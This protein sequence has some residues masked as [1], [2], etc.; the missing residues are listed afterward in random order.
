MSARIDDPIGAFVDH[1]PG[2]IEGSG[3][4]PLAGLTF[5]VKDLYHIEGHVTGGGSPDWLRA[6]E[7]ATGTATAVTKLLDAGADM[8]GKTVCD[9]LFYSFSGANAH[10]GT[11]TNVRAPG[12]VPGGSSSGSAAAVAAGLCDFA[13][14]TDTGGSIRLPASFGGIYGLRP[15]RGRVDMTHTM[16]MAPSYDVGGW[17]ADDAELY[18]TVGGVLLGGDR[19]RTPVSRVLIA[20]DAFDFADEAIAGVLRDYVDEIT[21]ALPPMEPASIA[22]FDWSAVRECFRALQAA[23]T[24]NTYGAWI[25][26]NSPALGPGIKERYAWAATVGP[27]DVASALA[28][29]EEIVA[30]LR[31]RIVPGTLVCLPTA[32]TLPA[33]LDA[34]DDELE[35][36]RTRTVPL[37]SLSGLSGLP[38]ISI[39][40]AS[41]DGCPVGLSFIGW[42]NADE[43]LLDLAVSLATIASR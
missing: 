36:F 41:H 10:Y 22:P 40:A 38:Q 32:A 23:E 26:A 6:H 20:D 4:G 12:R 7:P 18:R 15:S 17:F 19:D 33:R 21:P 13:L 24:W 2:R 1:G 5:A 16:D 37:V 8:I 31:S 34:A 42:P 43:V 29:R 35:A 25:E 14:G 28:K 9:E 11:P 3:E 39:P 27:A 30:N